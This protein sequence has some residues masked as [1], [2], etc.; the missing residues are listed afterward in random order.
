MRNPFTR[1]DSPGLK[2]LYWPTA[3]VAGEV[4]RQSTVLGL[5]L[6]FN[7]QDN[8]VKWVD[9]PKR[10]KLILPSLSRQQVELLLTESE[11]TR[12]KAIIVLFTESGLRL[13]ELANVRADDINRHSRTIRTLGKGSKEGYAPFGPLSEGHLTAWLAEYQPGD[14]TIWGINADGIDSMLGRLRRKTGLPCNAHTFRRTFASLLRKAGV[15]SLTIRDLGRWESIAMVE[16]YT[17]S[18]TFED[19][20]KHYKAPLGA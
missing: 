6:P 10:P 11:S 3:T 8:P 19:S 1:I 16:R 18:V 17:R 5:H 15:D 4:L 20:L 13:S 2:R 9:A 7:Y 14:A 12:D